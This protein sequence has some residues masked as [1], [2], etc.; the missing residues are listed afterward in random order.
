MPS[1]DTYAHAF[2]RRD[3]GVMPPLLPL[4]AGGDAIPDGDERNGPSLPIRAD[5]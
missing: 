5:Q 1:L 4:T 3:S 2:F